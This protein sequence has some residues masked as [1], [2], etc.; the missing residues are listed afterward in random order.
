MKLCLFG[1]AFAALRRWSR[2]PF[3][4]KTR[5][6][7]AQITEEQKKVQKKINSTGNKAQ[8]YLISESS[9]H[10]IS[11]LV[12]TNS[13][14]GKNFTALGEKMLLQGE[15]SEMFSVIL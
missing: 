11:D 5:G 13:L 6:S 2:K 4:Q 7:D 9:S 12:F 14:L 3:G 10:Q 15:K 8:V 1:V